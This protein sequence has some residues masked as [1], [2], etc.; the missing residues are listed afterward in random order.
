MLS[1]QSVGQRKETINPAMLKHEVRDR[2]KPTAE[3]LGEYKRYKDTSD[4]VSPMAVPGMHGGM[5]Q[6]NGLE[7]DEGGRPTN[8]YLTH[9][10]MN[11]KR[12]RKM[13][14][15]RDRYHFFRRYGPEK[16]ELGILCWG[17]SKGP[18]QQ[19]VIEANERGLKV[20]AFVPQV[21]YPFPKKQFEEFVASVDEL[22]VVELS[23]T[24]QFYKY[25][26]TFL[27]LPEGRTHV[28]KRSGAKDLSVA[29]VTREIEKLR[30]G[31]EAPE[32]E[33]IA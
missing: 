18:V 23:Y 7:H 9:E 16:A 22:L 28:F 8:M 15:I 6:T 4:G 19:A 32:V 1:D 20:A 25:L 11:A 12:Y 10:K 14:P 27:D 17:S 33:V 3:E 31:V 5:Y 24:A 13:W 30:A 2:V 21:L 26:R 29:E